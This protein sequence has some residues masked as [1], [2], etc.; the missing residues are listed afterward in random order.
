MFLKSFTN[1]LKTI[2]TSIIKYKF[3]IPYWVRIA[4][5]KPKCLYY[6]GPFSSRTEAK[7]MQHGY[8]EDLIAEKAIGIGIKI[9]RY[10]PTQLTITE[11]ESLVE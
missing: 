11:E 10:L 4:T 1:R 8:V 5:E 7:A 6:F 2:S 9:Q 3:T